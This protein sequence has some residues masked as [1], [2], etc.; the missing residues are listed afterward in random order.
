MLTSPAMSGAELG[1]D[2]GSRHNLGLLLRHVHL[3]GPLS[4]AALAQRMNLNRSTIMALTTKL[5][6]A[7]LVSERRPVTAA[8]RAARRSS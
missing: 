5:N 1:R 7:G 8:R 3:S 4:R 6:A 2:E